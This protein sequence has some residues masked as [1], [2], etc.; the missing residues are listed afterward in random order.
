MVQ[1]SCAALAFGSAGELLGIG[2]TKLGATVRRSVELPS[3]T[4]MVSDREFF[5]G[6]GFG[7]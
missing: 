3:L 1:K 4:S 7:G 5:D 6:F 2:L